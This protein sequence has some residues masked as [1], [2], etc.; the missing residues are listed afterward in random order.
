M[1]AERYDKRVEVRID[2]EVLLFL[3]AAMSPTNQS[4]SLATPQRTRARWAFAEK[5]VEEWHQ[6]YHDKE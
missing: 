2:D 3:A 1:T 5:L 6:R 4:P